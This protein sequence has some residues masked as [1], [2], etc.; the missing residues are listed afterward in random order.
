[1]LGQMYFD[2]TLGEPLWYNG[3]NWVL[4]TGVTA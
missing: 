4:A 1:V 2:T 3:S